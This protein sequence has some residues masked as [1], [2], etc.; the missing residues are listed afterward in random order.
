MSAWEMVL[1]TV[2]AFVV[3]YVW[4]RILGKKLISQMTFFDF[5]AGI[6]IGTLTGSVIFTSTIPLW[7]GLLGL[8]VF[9]LL[10]LLTGILS[11]KSY[12]W[13][14][15]LNG[16]PSLIIKD[17]KIQE[18]ALSK[19]RLTIDDVLFLLRE[20]NVFYLDEVELAYFETNG[21]LSVLKKPDIMPVTRKDMKF[22]R[23][24]RGLPHNLVIDGKIIAENL[25]A[26][27]KDEKWLLSILRAQGVS[28]ISE[29][30]F[31]QMDDGNSLYFDLR[32]DRSPRLH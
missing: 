5:V 28:D 18:Q 8:S 9:A 23:S 7:V 29:V 25:Q 1:R 11:L 6:T 22:H 4:A 13:R 19:N 10:C 27:H 2:V 12:R 21:Q 24:S 17:G 3:L 31:A 30:V 26:I 32:D 14:G 16:K 20:K 15:V